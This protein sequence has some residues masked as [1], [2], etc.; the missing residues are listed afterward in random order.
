MTTLESIM[1][2]IDAIL[3]EAETDPYGL[4]PNGHPLRYEIGLA[5]IDYAELI[6]LRSHVTPE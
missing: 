1:Y 5:M 2:R 6:L 4:L 3:R